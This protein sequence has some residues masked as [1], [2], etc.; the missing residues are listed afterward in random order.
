[1]LFHRA[2]DIWK[3]EMDIHATI[4]SRFFVRTSYALSI[5]RYIARPHLVE[6]WKKLYKNVT[7]TIPSQADVDCVISEANVNVLEGKV[8]I[9][10]ML[11]LL[12]VA[13][14]LRTMVSD[15]RGGLKRVLR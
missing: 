10:P 15:E 1:M 4:K 12:L 2:V 8:F 5:Y 7:F 6:N 11:C 13:T 3:M 14:Q 9:F